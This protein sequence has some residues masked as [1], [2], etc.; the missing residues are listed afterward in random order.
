MNKDK[1]FLSSW[2]SLK[3]SWERWIS[4]FYANCQGG[5]GRRQGP[6]P[7][8][9]LSNGSPRRE[10][11]I[12]WQWDLNSCCDTNYFS[13]SRNT[14]K[15]FKEDEYFWEYSSFSGG[16][17]LVALK[18]LSKTG[19]VYFIK[20]STSGAPPVGLK[21]HQDTNWGHSWCILYFIN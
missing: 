14:N 2:W 7:P 17:Y 5:K 15:N 21:S 9:S 20:L 1:H 4:R 16:P 11:S 10:G 3:H 6:F 12:V 19:E 8:I 13:L 18:G